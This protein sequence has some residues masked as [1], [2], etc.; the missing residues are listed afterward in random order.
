[1][2]GF[3][4]TTTLWPAPTQNGWGYIDQVGHFASSLRFVVARRFS[5][6]LAA[7]SNGQLY[8]FIDASG[9]V[10]IPFTFE[11]ATFFTDDLGNV[12]SGGKWG[13]IDRTGK[14]VIRAQFDRPS[15]FSDGFAEIP[16]PFEA[17][18]KANFIDHSGHPVWPLSR[19]DQVIDYNDGLAWKGEFKVDPVKHLPQEVWTVIDEHQQSISEPIPSCLVPGVFGD[20]LASLRRDC[21]VKIGYVDKFG[22]Q[23]I[24]AD[25][26]F[27]RPFSEGL[28][29]VRVGNKWGVID[30]SGG[31]VVQLKFAYLTEFSSGLAAAAV[32][33]KYG[34]IDHTGAWA[35]PPDFPLP[36]GA[37]LAKF[38][39]GF[40]GEL[41][42]ILAVK[43]TPKPDVT[44]AYINK[45]GKYVYGP[46]SLAAAH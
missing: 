9:Q 33:A 6:G 19:I 29:A 14:F 26:D 46:V 15:N 37:N 42:M 18:R 32:G 28:A 44:M 27:A 17:R 1:M 3:A 35:I 45:A 39:R 10:V 20:G 13:Y 36:E 24:P 12:R 7:V 4:Q 25:Y 41:A 34:F 8:G 21:N 43:T 38:V 30:K 2:A 22:K 23:A 5:G 40:D 31:F 16:V 11:D